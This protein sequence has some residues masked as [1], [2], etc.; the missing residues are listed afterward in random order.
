[1]RF[2]PLLL[3]AFS[4]CSNAQESANSRIKDITIYLQGARVTRDVELTVISG[5]NEIVISDLSPE[6]TSESIMVSQLNGMS[7]S[8]VNYSTTSL[9][10]KTSSENLKLITRSLDSVQQALY[11]FNSR[12]KGNREEVAILQT[13][14]QLNSKDTGMSLAQ[15][16]A[17]ASYY[18]DRLEALSLKEYEYNDTIEELLERQTELENEKSKINPAANEMRGE[19]RLS[20]NSTKAM[21]STIKITYNLSNAGW[22]P[23]YDI[24]AAGGSNNVD[25][26]FKGQVYQT[27]GTDWDNAMI[28]LSTSDPYQDNTKPDL[29]EKRLNFVRYNRRSM[30]VSRG[31][32]RYNPTVKTVSGKVTDVTGEPLL[33]ATVIVRG[34]NNATT[35]DFDG[36]YRLEITDGT[37]ITTSFSGYESVTSPIYASTMNFELSVSLDAVVVTGYRTSTRKK[38]NVTASVEDKEEL[39][40]VS[41]VEENLASRS[42]KLRLPYSIPSTGETI[43]I[44]ISQDK[45]DATYGYY[46]APVINQ[47]VFLTAQMKN[48]ESLNLIPAEASVY[49][50]DSFTGSIY[51][52]TDTTD[53][54]LTVSLGVDPQIS[55]ERK[56]VTDFK[57]QSI[58][59]TKKR[60]DKVYEIIVK[61]NRSKSIDLKLQDRIPIS[62]NKEIEVD[63]IET[64]DATMDQETRLLT[65]DI[66][67]NTGS[68]VKKRFSYQLE[69][70]KNKRINLD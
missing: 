42:Y 40:T 48:W 37:S 60:V 29:K 61:N 66:N 32:R 7:L 27:T 5:S 55:V 46:S 67:L 35:T 34:T 49:F 1:M 41:A 70:P 64:G 39:S 47:N 62:S 30:S 44:P 20:I 21:K 51:F 56:E 8:S 12:L 2:L 10:K 57:S 36:N 43:D 68:Q 19:I 52:D 54:S 58:F 65:W 11:Q 15:V 26:K 24:Y 25:L 59:G 4:L 23:Y 28:T 14:R 31:N 13:N 18:N 38:S 69:Y 63:D 22:V 33:G 9:S 17:F 50:D 3:L 16:K 45:L 53:E 6:I